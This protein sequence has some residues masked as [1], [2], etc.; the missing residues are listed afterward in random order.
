M[1][2]TVFLWIVGLVLG[3]MIPAIP[4]HAEVGVSDSEIKVGGIV[5]LSGPIAFMGKGVRDGALLY[6]KF[7]NDQGGV[8][9]RKINYIV[10]DDTYQGPRA[11]AAAKKLVSKD[12]VFCIFMILGSLQTNALYPAMEKEGVPILFP[13]TQTRDMGIPPKK[14][15]FHADTSYTTQS[16]IAI[17]YIVEELKDKKPRIGVLYQDD[18]PG[19]D[20]L[21]G[22]HIAA[23]H[24]GFELVAEESYK[25][26]AIDFSPQ[27]A[28]LNSAKADYVTMWTLV[29]EPAAILKEA[30]RIQY[31]P[32]WI[33]STA[34]A[35]NRVIALAG[36]AA[37][38]GKGF[39]ATGIAHNVLVED[40]AKIREFKE[41]MKKFQL[42]ELNNFYN[43][44][45]YGAAT[46]LVEGLKRTGK[47]LTREGLIKALETFKDYDNGV[48]SPVTWGP[49]LRAG[50]TSIQMGKAEKGVWLP[51]G[52]WRKSKIPED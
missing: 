28:K 38:F 19:Q 50:G 52:S 49:N 43:W 34:S 4:A 31:K 3:L 51:F 6:F 48:L 20:W 39:L 41:S 24:Y 32:L 23:K 45:G 11:V 46:T 18:L 25:R 30:M 44:Y 15:L 21:R 8:Y 7:I 1:K 29:R 37:Y 42:G 9:G 17:E 5:D 13:A 36:E 16:K 33:T 27:V 35:D 14:Y 26:G 47:D 12:Q 22:A 10:E 40:S 2:R